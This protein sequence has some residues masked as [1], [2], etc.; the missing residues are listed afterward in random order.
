M[1]IRTV[2]EAHQPPANP[3]L[4][5]TYCNKDHHTVNHC[6]KLNGYPHGHKL[7]RGGSNSSGHVNT[8]SAS[9]NGSHNKWRASS[10]YAYQVQA[11]SPATAAQI[12]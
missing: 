7:Y 5:C 4:H 11:G 1:E 10:S 3:Q 6:H 8:G 12:E 9:R 2:L